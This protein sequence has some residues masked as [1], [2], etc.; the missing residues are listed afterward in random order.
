[1]GLFSFLSSRRPTAASYIPLPT[2][3]SSSSSFGSPSPPSSPRPR[4]RSGSLTLPL[5]HSPAA[6]SS[7]NL[8][9]SSRRTLVRILVH[10]SPFRLVVLAVF[11]LT[12]GHW[13][14]ISSS[15]SSASPSTSPTN[16]E[17]AT[18]IA[19]DK[20]HKVFED[21]SPGQGDTRVLPMRVYDRMSD[22]CV[23]EW[24]ITHRWGAACRGTDLSEGYAVDG[25]WAWVN[26]SDPA[27]VAS[28]RA[29]KPTGTPLKIDADHRYADHNELL[30][31]MRSFLASVGPSVLQ[32]LHILAS[33]YPLDEQKVGDGTKMVGQIPAWLSKPASV[34]TDEGPIILHH[35]SS[36]FQPLPIPPNT[37]MSG[38]EVDAWRHATLPS[39][40]S[41]AVESQLPN[42]PAPLSDTLVYLNDDFITLRPNT[43]ADYTS[44]LFGPLLRSLTDLSSLYLPSEYPFQRLWNPAGEEV[45]IKRAAWVLGR[46]FGMRKVPYIQHH[47]RTLVRP[48]LRE[49][50]LAFPGAF[51]DTAKARYRAQQDVP[52][53]VQPFAL[54]SWFVVQRHR[55]ALLWTWAV[56]KHGGLSG[57]LTPEIKDA[58]WADVVGAGERDAGASSFAVKAPAREPVENTGA[59]VRAAEGGPGVHPPLNAQYSFSA[60]DGYA[61]HYVDRLWWW[62]LPRSGYPD[63]TR[64][65]SPVYAS[66]GSRK[67]ERNADGSIRY[68]VDEGKRLRLCTLSRSTCL[69]P[70]VEEPAE[71]LFKRI[72]FERASD[73]GDCAI[74]ALVGASGL[75]GIEAFMPR[76]GAVVPSG[77]V[78]HREA[79]FGAVRRVESRVAHLPVTSE[80]RETDFRL[81]AVLAQAGYGGPR[82]GGG[83]GGEESEGEEID[84]RAWTARLVQRYQYVMG[85]A[86]AELFK[87]MYPDKVR[88]R[89]DRASKEMKGQAD[90]AP[91]GGLTFL[92]LNDDI[93]KGRKE[94]DGMLRAWFEEHWPERM[95]DEVEEVY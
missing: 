58:M 31:S 69:K 72:A 68:K 45:G 84:L 67:P 65:V 88:A 1:M 20:W 83:E 18:L 77:Y 78:A 12:A 28:R 16:E 11:L 66:S 82:Y 19:D 75:S 38:E 6:R 54:A 93:V 92:C 91:D 60:K 46:R 7:L 80:W 64:A 15:S 35:D 52:P 34:R 21:Q 43:P 25:V 59:F 10:L 37:S 73:C 4:P 5:A 86:P 90:G 85:S 41:L 53:S 23:K 89:L 39:F 36:Y 22:A 49:A 26:G 56:A 48:L 44:P 33:A 51:G 2:L 32:R 55:E 74:A 14:S 50:A 81:G 62:D 17:L 79:E 30:Y 9:P 29:Y 27:Q 40:N 87:L 8:S 42:T 13:Y 3:A 24:V 76:E 94:I 61:L 95:S 47:P 63:L 57:T 71:E 70:G